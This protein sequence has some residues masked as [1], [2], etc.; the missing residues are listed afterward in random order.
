[1]AKL[2]VGISHIFNVK[3]ESTDFELE[4]CVAKMSRSL[5]S[6]GEYYLL[7]KI[8]VFLHLCEDGKI[9]MVLPTN[10]EK[11]KRRINAA[12]D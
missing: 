2:E 11:T 8:P 7:D 6:I 3:I 5:K 12:K 1:M 10:I 9:H 4:V